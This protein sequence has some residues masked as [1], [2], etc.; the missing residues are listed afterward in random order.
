[1][2][3][4]DSVLPGSVLTLSSMSRLN[5]SA[6]LKYTL[7]RTSNMQLRCLFYFPLGILNIRGEKEG[8][9]C[10]K[11]KFWLDCLTLC[12]NLSYVYFLHASHFSRCDVLGRVWRCEYLPG[13]TVCKCLSRQPR[14]Q[15]LE[16]AHVACRK[17]WMWFEKTLC[18]NCVVTVVS[19]S[20][21]IVLCGF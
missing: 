14:Q 4:R 20:S 8:F 5:D 16:K 9:T 2:S 13:G 21:S 11:T 17:L 15:V 18:P 6:W 19:S 10:S 12:S 1:M 3:F 7:E